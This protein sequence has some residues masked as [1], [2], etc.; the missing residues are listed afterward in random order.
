MSEMVRRILVSVS[1]VFMV[2]GTL[3]GFGVIG[4]RVEESSGEIGRAHV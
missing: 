3:Y 2:L 1:A 4:E